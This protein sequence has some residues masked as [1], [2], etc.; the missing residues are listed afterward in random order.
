MSDYID[1]PKILVPLQIEAIVLCA[2]SPI[3]AEEILNCI[4]KA[5]G[6]TLT[7]EEIESYLHQL[8]EKYQQNTYV[9]E[10]IKISGGYQFLT[11]KEY[12]P[13]LSILLS[14]K[15]QKSLSSA[16][17]ETLAII[18]YKQ[19]ITKSEIEEIRGVNVDYSIQKL[20]DKALIQI[21]GKSNLPGRPLIYST[22]GPF[23]EYFKLNSIQ[24]LP[25]IKDLTPE[26]NSINK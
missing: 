26:N 17:L 9:L 8:E 15:N 14:Q 12:A 7:I 18:A 5:V 1:E 10:L 2:E 13:T 11:K 20:L 4:Q 24:D 16:A 22:S 21:D 23:M 19:P 25:Q 3:Q 6:Q